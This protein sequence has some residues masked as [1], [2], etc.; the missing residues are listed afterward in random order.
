MK[1]LENTKNIRFKKKMQKYPNFWGVDPRGFQKCGVVTPATP[2]RRRP[3]WHNA[4][5]QKNG[6]WRDQVRV[7]SCF[8]GCGDHRRRDGGRHRGT[9][10]ACPF[11]CGP[12]CAL[13]PCMEVMRQ[14]IGAAPPPR[15]TELFRRRGCGVLVLQLQ[16][17]MIK[18]ICFS[19]ILR[20]FFT[21][22]GRSCL[23]DFI[24]L[25]V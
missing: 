12:P 8:S 21:G 23:E 24:S 16:F 4:S 20:F 13:P 1:M 6:G 18:L 15:W 9:V 11:E 25:L 22:M 5:R 7:Q 17:R 3:W 10:P 14:E 2:R 19:Q